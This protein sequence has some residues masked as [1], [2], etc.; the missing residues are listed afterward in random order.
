MQ[1]E[2]PPRRLVRAK[3]IY[4]EPG[5][6]GRLPISKPTFF[7]GLRKGFYPPGR[8][9]SPNVRVWTEEEVVLMEEGR[10]A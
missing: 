4:S 5:R 10:A 9:I 3:Q 8:W 7:A 6:P 2:T 1:H